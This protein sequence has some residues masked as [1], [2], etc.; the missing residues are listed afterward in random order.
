MILVWNVKDTLFE[1]LSLVVFIWDIEVNIYG[2]FKFVLMIF[3]HFG[4]NAQSSQLLFQIYEGR[5][6]RGGQTVFKSCWTFLIR[7]LRTSSICF[8]SFIFPLSISW[9]CIL[10]ANPPSSILP[11]PASTGI[12]ANADKGF[13]SNLHGAAN[14]ALCPHLTSC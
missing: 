7:Y 5:L 3:Q 8:S 6:T 12:T 11:S 4:T 1:L 10:A 2:T 14:V 9:N 13:A